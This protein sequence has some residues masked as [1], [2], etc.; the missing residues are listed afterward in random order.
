MN[1]TNPGKEGMKDGK[2][3]HHLCPRVSMSL[4]GEDEGLIRS[5]SV[6]KV[7]IRA[8]KKRGIVKKKKGVKRLSRTCDE[9]MEMFI[10]CNRVRAEMLE[11]CV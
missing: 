3:E 2:K 11:T 1:K 4:T 10:D 8:D 7:N 6:C 5:G 9:E